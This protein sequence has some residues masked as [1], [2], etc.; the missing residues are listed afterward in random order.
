MPDPIPDYRHSTTLDVLCNGFVSAND[1]AAIGDG[2]GATFPDVSDS[3]APTQI[4]PSAQLCSRVGLFVSS[5]H[6]TRLLEERSWP[7]KVEHL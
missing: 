6:A 5:C 7:R 4:H 2:E 1:V 3:A